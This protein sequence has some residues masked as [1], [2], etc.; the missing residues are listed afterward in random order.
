M[1]ISFDFDCTLGEAIIQ[2]LASYLLSSKAEIFI[3]T[4]RGINDHS[5]TDLFGVAKRLGIIKENIHFTEGAYK[6]RKI[7]ELEIDMHFDD[8]PEECELIVQHT[9]CIPMLIW[10]NYCKESILNDSFAKNIN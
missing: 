3:I 10:D 5:Q 9:G 6:W 2:R 7:K 4:S 1:K 8:V